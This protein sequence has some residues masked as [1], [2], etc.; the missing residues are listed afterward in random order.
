MNEVQPNCLTCRSLGRVYDEPRFACNRFH[1]CIG[2]DK[3][4]AREI[5]KMWETNGGATENQSRIFDSY[6]ELF[7]EVV[8]QAVQEILIERSACAN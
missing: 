3:Y 5:L 8:K 4:Q 1:P 2:G 7:K 6:P